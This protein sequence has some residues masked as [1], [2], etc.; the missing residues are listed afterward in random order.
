M[1]IKLLRA[2]AISG[3]HCDIDEVVEV[4]EKD[5]KYLVN[6]K[7]AQLADGAAK[8]KKQL[9]KKESIIMRR[10]GRVAGNHV[11]L[12]DVV[13]VLEADAKFLLGHGYAYL[14]ASDEAKELKA[15]LKNA[16]EKEAGQ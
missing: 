9:V 12:G 10:N 8:A 13:S 14:A 1:K 15:D 2:S 4:S 7:L 3:V 5:G 11:E 16:A 6:A